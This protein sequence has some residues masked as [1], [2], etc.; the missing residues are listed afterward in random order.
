ML[1]TVEQLE[2]AYGCETADG[3]GRVPPTYELLLTM[4]LALKNDG[5]DAIYSIKSV[6]THPECVRGI[7]EFCGDEEIFELSAISHAMPALTI[8]TQ[9]TREYLKAWT[10][11]QSVMRELKKHG[12]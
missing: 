3:R 10:A 5:I 7:L 9:K 6:I 2:R 8:E 11:R 4:F 1:L 12:L